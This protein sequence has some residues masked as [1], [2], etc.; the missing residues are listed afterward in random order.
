M[1]AG[2]MLVAVSTFAIFVSCAAAVVASA[3]ETLPDRAIV[4]GHPL[5]PRADQFGGASSHTPRDVSSSEAKEID[6]LYRQL[7]REGTPP[8]SQS[9]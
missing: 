6:E 4:N 9:R 3:A 1:L 7:M 5:Q 2:R 8:A